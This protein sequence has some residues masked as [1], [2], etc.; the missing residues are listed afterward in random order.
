MQADKMASVINEL[1]LTL[2]SN[3]WNTKGSDSEIGIRL[4]CEP[5]DKCTEHSFKDRQGK[6][7]YTWHLTPIH[8]IWPPQVIAGF[9]WIIET[10]KSEI[11]I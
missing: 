6:F 7:Q 1:C 9:K 10:D 11:R 3:W 2:I 5:K 8:D 4:I